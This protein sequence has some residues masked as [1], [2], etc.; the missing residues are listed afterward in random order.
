MGVRIVGT[1]Q[2]K[3]KVVLQNTA[4]HN[5]DNA[6]CWPEGVSIQFTSGLSPTDALPQMLIAGQDN[7]FNIS[8]KE[9]LD[10]KQF[11]VCVISSQQPR[12]CHQLL[13]LDCVT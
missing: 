1:K 11:E 5:E 10:F 7:S 2:C 13:H 6:G 4:S 8:T 12:D 3:A 9:E